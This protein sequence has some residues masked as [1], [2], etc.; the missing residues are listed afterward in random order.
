MTVYLATFKKFFTWMGGTG[1]VSPQMVAEVR[2]TLKEER[3]VLLR[4]V[5]E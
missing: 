4:A 2:S 3:H 1:L 5:E